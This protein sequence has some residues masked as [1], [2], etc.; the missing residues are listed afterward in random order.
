VSR[1]RENL[2]H[3]SMGGGRRPTPVDSLS[4]GAR[5]LPPT[6]PLLLARVVDAPVALTGEVDLRDQPEAS[7]KIAFAGRSLDPPDSETFKGPADALSL[8]ERRAFRT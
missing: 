3:G 1:V 7:F 4:R 5:R 6:R 8:S 2:T